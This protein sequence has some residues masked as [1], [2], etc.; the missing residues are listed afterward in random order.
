MYVSIL[1]LVL[2]NRY[3]PLHN[4]CIVNFKTTNRK[5]N[6]VYVVFKGSFRA[7]KIFKRKFDQKSLT[8]RY[9][10]Y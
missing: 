10:N 3:K 6:N 4:N 7:H 9:K 2:A 5:E 1:I 8:A